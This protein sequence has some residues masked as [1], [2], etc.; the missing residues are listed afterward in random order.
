MANHYLIDRRTTASVETGTAH[1]NPKWENKAVTATSFTNVGKT[2]ISEATKATTTYTN[3]NERIMQ[4]VFWGE[5]ATDQNS[6]TF[7]NTVKIGFARVTGGCTAAVAKETAIQEYITLTKVSNTQ[8]TYNYFVDSETV[9][10]DSFVFILDDSL[11]IAN[12][13]AVVTSAQIDT[14]GVGS[15]ISVS[16]YDNT[17]TAVTTEIEAANRP[18]FVEFTAATNYHILTATVTATYEGVTTTSTFDDTHTSGNINFDADTTIYIVATA[19][20]VSPTE[21]SINVNASNSVYT[22]K[23]KD[24]NDIN[25]Y[26]NEIIPLTFTAKANEGY[27]FENAPR[28]AYF[29]RYN[30]PVTE[31][32][33]E[34]TSTGIYSISIS[35]TSGAI[36]FYANAAAETVIKNKYGIITLYNPSLDDLK[37]IA[38]AR[39]FYETDTYSTRYYKD[40][41]DYIA[42]LQVVYCSFSNL[43]TQRL[44]LGNFSVGSNLIPVIDNNVVILDC[45][46]IEIDGKY[47]NVVD[48]NA[49]IKIYLPFMG[50]RNLET[51]N[52]MDKTI[53][54]YYKL[55]L[56][57]GGAKAFLA[58][59]ETVNNETVE[60]IIET[61]DCQMGYNVPFVLLNDVKGGYE[62]NAN[63]MYGFTPF[64]LVDYPKTT[65]D[66]TT[67]GNA[68]N[69]CALIGSYQGYT[70]FDEITLITSA[71]E[72]E[73]NEIINM[74][75]S[76][77]IV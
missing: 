28:V 56:V 45:G 26:N 31:Y 9:G 58:T 22:V 34:D 24:G 18:L 46:N 14:S 69:T 13:A 47:N 38:R 50:F 11:Q 75:E 32:L 68:V 77:V 70:E 40:L 25:S 30:N 51:V 73:R 15:N 6:Y 44:Y 67:Y 76:G 36:N 4:L 66:N 35:P 33:T 57:S 37:D 39:Y 27:Y 41:G 74:L 2:A 49:T 65:G 59:V 20:H 71:T 52:V 3:A 8:F 43:R 12:A 23:D 1:V 21:Y 64:V 55:D 63:F 10:S 54:L 62:L 42:K 17:E 60:T 72:T 5:T 61:F 7:G 19:E 16:M 53:H 48:Y 29:D